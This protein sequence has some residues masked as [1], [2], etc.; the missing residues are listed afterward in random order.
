M[1]EPLLSD[2]SIAIEDLPQAIFWGSMTVAI[3][4]ATHYLRVVAGRSFDAFLPALGVGDAEQRAARYELTVMPA[5]PVLALTVISFAITPIYYVVDPVASQVVGDSPAGLVARW[6]SESLTSTVV[7]ALLLQAIRQMRRVDRLHAAAR[8]IDPF[9]PMPIYAFSRLTARTASVLILFNAAGVV[10]N[11]QVLDSQSL[12]ALY[13]PWFAA[14]LGAA[15][16]I[17]F[18]PLIGMHRRLEAI[19]DGHEAEA[20]GRLSALLAELNRAIDD[21]DDQRV[22]SLDGS[23]TALRHEQ[24]L[25]ARLPTWPWS[26]G[27]LR[28][29]GSALLLPIVLLLIQRVLDQVLG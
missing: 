19:R 10:G 18:V 22:R 1:L 9:Q 12:F 8:H 14:F 6:I 7:L 3:L 26:T 20:G 17:F 2:H 24:E 27:T 29:F 15:I 28:G 25:L 13:L 16:A 5:L 4:A 21:R 23:I 11:A